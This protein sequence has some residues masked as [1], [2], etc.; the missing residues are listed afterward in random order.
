V[1]RELLEKASVK[2]FT[3]SQVEE[4]MAST[5][6]I[7]YK[8]GERAELLADSIVLAVGL[9]PEMQ[10]KKITSRCQQIFGPLP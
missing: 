2:T 9:A 6:R 5:I 7:A 4:I 8:D 3:S 1:L 10:V